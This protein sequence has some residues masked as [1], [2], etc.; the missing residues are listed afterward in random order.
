[1]AYVSWCNN[2]ICRVLRARELRCEERW[3]LC[4]TATD[5]LGRT[6]LMY[7]ASTMGGDDV[8]K[9]MLTTGRAALSASAPEGE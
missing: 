7:A 9:Q 8:I 1:M 2:E 5:R 4:L 3:K 6:P